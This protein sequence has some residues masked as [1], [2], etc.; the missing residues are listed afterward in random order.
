MKKVCAT[1]LLLLVIISAVI[2]TGCTDPDYIIP[3]G[4]YICDNPYIKFTVSETG[5]PVQEFT[6]D[7][8]VRKLIAD[9]SVDSGI[10]FYAPPSGDFETTATFDTIEGYDLVCKYYFK[11][12]RDGNELTITNSEDENEVYTLVKTEIPTEE[13][14]QGETTTEGTTEPETVVFEQYKYLQSSEQ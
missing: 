1:V 11:L 3:E 5:R 8:E 2:V 12:S 13:P 7:G 9:L 14:T 6:I 4:V 10:G